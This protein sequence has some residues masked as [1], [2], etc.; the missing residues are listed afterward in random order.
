VRL[1]SGSEQL[2]RDMLAEKG[3]DTSTLQL[4]GIKL[5]SM[6][7]G[8]GQQEIHYDIPEY[9]LARHCYTVLLYLTPTLSTAVPSLPVA[10]LRDTF[11]TGEKRPPPAA[12]QLLNRDRFYT[13]RVEAG[14]AM[15]LRGDVPHCGMANPDAHTRYLA[16]MLF[17]PRGVKQPD[18]EEQRYPHGVK[19]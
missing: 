9:S 17:S 4:A 19:D 18:T 3:I 14:D 7:R 12:L 11:S 13:T 2:G 8:E 5:L 15:L 10:A 1:L 6:E 16:F